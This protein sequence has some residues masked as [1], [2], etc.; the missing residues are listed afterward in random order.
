MHTCV[1]VSISFFRSQSTKNPL[2]W[3]IMD[4]TRYGRAE[5]KLPFP[6]LNLSTSVDQ[7]IK[8]R[9]IDLFF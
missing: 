3:R 9:I 4:M 1:V 2:N 5:S 7:K 8:K 6:M